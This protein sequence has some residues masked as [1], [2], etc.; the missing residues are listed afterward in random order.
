MYYVAQNANSALQK[1]KPGNE[2]QLT[3]TPDAEDATIITL[4]PVTISSDELAKIGT[5]E[6]VEGS[7]EKLLTA[8]VAKEYIDNKW[9]W[10]VIA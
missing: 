10:E 2:N 6:E 9:D 5:E 1:V 8:G 4:T 3:I 7:T